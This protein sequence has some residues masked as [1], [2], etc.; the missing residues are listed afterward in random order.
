MNDS[1]RAVWHGEAGFT[2]SALAALAGE[3]SDHPSAVSSSAARY[4]AAG[5]PA[6]KLGA[7]LGTYGQCWQ[8]VNDMRQP[9]GGSAGVVAGDN[10]MTYATI[11]S[12][13]YNA[14]YY[15]WDAAASMGY[16]AFPAAT[17][18]RGCTLVSYENPQSATAKGAWVKANGLG[19]A[20][21]W[22]INQGHVG[23]AAAGQ[24]DPITQ[25]LYTAM[26][27]AG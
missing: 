12:S 27:S 16:L 6:A 8:G 9:L 24:Q 14:S 13:Y 23:T 17:G 15:K 25:A 7:G 18:P 11:L 20:I 10:V 1:G 2:L 19:G 26:Q 21:V 5:V 22:T 3:G 4:R